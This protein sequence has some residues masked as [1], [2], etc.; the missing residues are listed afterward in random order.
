M[1]ATG[2]VTGGEVISCIITRRGINWTAQSF[3]T[4][5]TLWCRVLSCYRRMSV[6]TKARLVSSLSFLSTSLS[7]SLYLPGMKKVENA[8]GKG[9]RALKK[10][11]VIT[12]SGSCARLSIHTTGPTGA[13]RRGAS[14]AVEK[15]GRKND[16]QLFDFKSGLCII[17][18]KPNCSN[19]G[20]IQKGWRD[21]YFVVG[22][23][24]KKKKKL[25]RRTLGRSSC[26]ND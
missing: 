14:V 7:L 25:E 12:R 8:Q 11:V 20:W 16:E 4:A 3:F 5:F 13:A 21:G 15:K 17:Q 9:W 1:K 6:Y 10:T 19:P 18:Q 2:W 24:G 22:G 26:R 23:G